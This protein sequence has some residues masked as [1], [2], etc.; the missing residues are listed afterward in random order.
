MA[1]TRGRCPRCRV[2]YADLWDHL[3]KRH[4]D[5]AWSAAELRG[6]TLLAC[7]CG[8]VAR[9]D[10]GLK[11]HQGKVK[12][13]GLHQRHAA[14]SGSSRSVSRR[15]PSV[16][17]AGSARAPSTP[18]RRRASVSAPPADPIVLL[19]SP[20]DSEAV[21]PTR[22]RRSSAPPT[23]A[24]WSFGSWSDSEDGRP[25]SGPVP[26]P[27]PA[28][29]PA[30]ATAPAPALAPAQASAAGSA[31]D[32]G[33]PAP[34]DDLLDRFLSL[35]KLPTAVKP[36][37]GSQARLF[38]DAADRLASAFVA[39][40][41]DE[42]LFDFLCL[43]KVGLVP[44]LRAD[45]DLKQRL[46]AFP[47]VA[48]PELPSNADRGVRPPATI[49]EAVARQVTSGRLSRAARL[50]SGSAK[51]APLTPDVSAELKRKH[52]AGPARPF[53]AGIGPSPGMAPKADIVDEVFR[54]FKLDT[55]PGVS[56]WTQP[57]LSVALRRPAVVAFVSV[58]AGLVAQ[59]SA[60]GHQLLCASR[61]TPLIKS[62]GGIRPI[63][64]GELLFRLVSKVLLR[65]YFKPDM[66][67]PS[68]LGVGSKGGVEPVVRAV[69]R[70]L[71]DDLPKTY[72]HLVSL[73]F[74]NAFNT[75]DRRELAAGLRNFA[76]ALYRAGRWVYGTPAQLAVTGADGA[77]DVL[78]SSQGV[79]QGDPFGPL[80]FSV[81][82][83][84]TLDDLVRYLGPD[85]LLLAYLDD[86]Y[87]L[88]PDDQAFSEVQ[89][90]FD[91]RGSSLQLNV[92]KS[93][94]HSLADIRRSGLELLG[95]AVGGP[96]FRRSFLEAKVDHQ[97]GLLRSL[98]DLKSQHALLLL[99]FC[100]QQD[101]RHLQ[102]TLRTDDLPGVWDDLDAAL[103]DAALLLRSSPRRLDTDADLVTLPARLG[104]LG[105]LSHAECAPLAFASGSEAADR[106]LAPALLLDVDDDKAVV[107]Q[108]AR[109]D[110]A[111]NTRLERVLRR[112]PGLERDTVSE[113]GTV[114]GRRW[115]GVVPFR[116]VLELSDAEVASGLHF[117][118]LCPGSLDF[119]A[120]CGDAAPF[121]HDEACSG[122]APV[123]LGR[124]E[125]IKRL[126]NNTLTS[127]AKFRVVLEPLVPGTQ[128][129]T[130]LRIAGPDGVRELDITVVS[131]AS[132]DAR[133]ASARVHSDLSLSLAKRSAS[134][135]DAIL[136]LAA[137]AKTL[138]YA[139]RIA[140]PFRPFVLS[141]GGA[142]E[143]GT[144][145]LLH[146]WREVL[147]PSSFSHLT[148]VLS[149]ILVRAR[150]RLGRL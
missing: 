112:L 130:D 113:S 25:A 23:P 116:S 106:A 77:V 138:K 129:R 29:A 139:G 38:A 21:T 57:L 49:A 69:E 30:S 71:V 15:A 105:V 96:A 20:S 87:V 136:A 126:V 144:L 98:G 108:R 79:R 88:S 56:G 120:D 124:H 34:V 92:A 16:P 104:G 132:Q 133:S 75:V 39:K 17:A 73:D 89:D 55:A 48:W 111:F 41:S 103:L 63:A 131:L 59:G 97:V 78:E 119:C 14:T 54:K 22:P 109:C 115:L 33:S 64:V 62:D 145:K 93:K 148:R 52:P 50:L 47:A 72:S 53:A 149:L 122:R 134:S 101:L 5:V 19:S 58:L 68:Q 11:S 128:L 27:A 117:R 82:V 141:S 121:G 67:L 140:A 61:L 4:K 81:A 146:A 127:N 2:E 45:V 90:F 6:T 150:A 74:S 135:V 86:I 100:I 7:P 36:L 1:T 8:A 40:P 32:D 46:A 99:R 65:H 43:P 80:F 12:C 125:Q 142:V 85:R 123:A 114:L 31:S 24:D 13:V 83:R 110:K 42:T 147:A 37:I 91:G 76:P 84:R 60:P 44:G 95:T 143:T 28:P 18:A 107:T 102:R 9:S 137:R 66:L 35:V 118:T 26:V 10:H 3:V 94:S 51:V 70:A